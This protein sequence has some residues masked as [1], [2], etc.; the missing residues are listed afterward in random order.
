MA[1]T[2]YSQTPLAK[3][4]GIKEGFN[5]RLVNQPDYY[6]NLFV[7]FPEN[8]AIKTEKKSK[9]NLIHFFTK[10]ASELND[11]ILQLKNEIELNGM[12]WISWPKK[13]SKIQTDITEDFVRHLALKNG[14]VDIKVCAIDEIWSGLKLVIPVKD[15]LT[16]R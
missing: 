1:T 6:F 4:I 9:K 7:D 3:K 16:S 13:A 14:L 15:R 11:H 10:D 8:V 2:A 12:I 5:I